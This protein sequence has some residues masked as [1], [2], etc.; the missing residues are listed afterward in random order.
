MASVFDVAAFILNRLGRVGAMQ[1]QKL[2]YYSQ[3]WSLVWDGEP[4]F[5]EV[6]EAWDKGPAIPEL[7]AKYAR[8]AFV[9]RVSIGDASQLSA[10]QQAS[11]SAVLDFYGKYSGAWLSRLTHREPPWLEARRAANG[12]RNAEITHRALREF[13]S[14]YS[15]QFRTIPDSVA[16]G[17]TLIVG[18]PDDVVDDVLHGPSVEVAGLE[19]WLETGEGDPWQT[20]GD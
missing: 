14:T 7:H 11:I 3:A 6:I 18:L 20:S 15:T 10:D 12:G 5:D 19:E 8:T 17:L 4:L 9:D 1:L 16:R 13:F 2:V